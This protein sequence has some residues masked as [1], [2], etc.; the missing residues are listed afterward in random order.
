MSLPKI[1]AK[2]LSAPFTLI[3]GYRLINP[4]VQDSYR[5]HLCQNYTMMKIEQVVHFS[6]GLDH[7]PWMKI[8][9]TNSLSK[10]FFLRN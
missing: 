9:S 4:A 5:I 7:L 2:L 10:S 1:K 3:A 6:V 8:C